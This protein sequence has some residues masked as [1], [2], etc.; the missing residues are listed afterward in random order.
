MENVPTIPAKSIVN[1]VKKPAAWFG[2]EYNMNIYRGCSHGC[3]YCDSRSACYRNTDF[4]TIK[5]KKDALRI[6]RDDLRR[7]VKT[8]VIATGS[9]SDPYNPL[10][11]EL[12]LTH[13]ALELVNAY[14][15]GV[16]IATKSSL[17]TRDIDVLKD[18]KTHSPTI[19]KITIT[20]ADDKLCGIIEPN[21]SRASERFEAISR[22]TD[23]GIYCGVLM[24]PILPFINDTEKNI[25]DILKMAKES[26]ARFVYP[27]FGM[28]LRQG[29]REYY[30]GQLDKSFPHIKEKHIKR[31][32]DRYVNTS[33]KSKMLWEIFSQECERL[34]L[35][36]DM[37]AITRQY[38]AGYIMQQMTLF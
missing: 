16:A 24:M 13:N 27:A 36:H 8:G 23:K 30:Y 32:G 9:M 15:F 5:V 31:Y 35:L 17:V 20:T 14:N 7:K 4:D 1:R 18:I 3:I 2:T 38:N 25:L 26:G 33:P 19:V 29:N 28:T 6:I 12:M 34:H 22:L 37:R 10:E 11:R 21:V